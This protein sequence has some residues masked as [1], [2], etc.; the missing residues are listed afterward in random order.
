MHKKMRHAS[1]LEVKKTQPFG[2][3]TINHEL[4]NCFVKILEIVM[5]NIGCA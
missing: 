3:F 4:Y 1:R 2:I 5:P